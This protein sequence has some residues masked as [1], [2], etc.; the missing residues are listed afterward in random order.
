[1]FD[2]SVY[3]ELLQKFAR[4][5]KKGNEQFSESFEY[6]KGNVNSRN[7]YSSLTLTTTEEFKINNFTYNSLP[8][9]F[10]I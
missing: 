10:P 4:K 5:L 9:P 2:C 6:H 8:E 3:I 1:M 7:D